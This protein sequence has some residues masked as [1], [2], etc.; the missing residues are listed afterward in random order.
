[1][2]ILIDLDNSPHVPFFLPLICEMERQ[3]HEVTITARDCFQTCGLLD[4]A[5]RDYETIGRHYGRRSVSKALGLLARSFQ[6]YRFARRR[7]FDVAASHGSRA[8]ILAAFLRRIPVV[9]IFDY[10]FSRFGPVLARLPAKQIVPSVISDSECA[11]LGCNVGRIVRYPGLK[12]QVYVGDFRPDGSLLRK[13]G[14]DPDRTLVTVRPPANEAHYHN[15][16]SEDL[17]VG[18]LRELS[19]REDVTT[20]VLPRNERQ[21]DELGRVLPADR[22]GIV[23]LDEVVDGLNLIWHSDLVV[24]GGGTMNREA[25]VLGVPVYSIFRG[26]IG[27]VDRSLVADGR[28]KLVGSLDDMRAINMTKRDKTKSRIAGG[29]ADLVG[30]LVREILTTAESFSAES[31]ARAEMHSDSSAGQWCVDVDSL[32]DKMAFFDFW[33]IPVSVGSEG[34]DV[35]ELRMLTQ[36]SFDGNCANAVVFLRPSGQAGLYQLGN[37]IRFFGR[38]RA[39]EKHPAH[40]KR[41][42]SIADAQGRIVSHVLEDVS[43]RTVYFPFSLDEVFNNYHYEAYSNGKRTVSGLALS[44]YYLVK[45]LIPRT[46]LGQARGAWAKVQARKS[47]PEFPVDR[48]FEDLKRYILAAALRVSRSERLPFVWFWPEGKEAA[49]VLTH[50]VEGGLKDNAGI[51]RLLAA[52]KKRGLASSFNIVPFKYQV[53]MSI[54][55][56]LK[57]EGCEV[58][59]HGYNH[60]GK[61]FSSRAVFEKRVDRLNAVAGLWQAAGFRAASTYRNPYWLSAMS[62]DYDSSFF[63]TDPYEPQP[64]GCLSLFPYSIGNVIEIPMTLPQDHTLLTVLKHR[65]IGMWTRKADLIREANGMIC[66]NTHPDEGYIGD[67]DRVRHYEDFLER[68]RDAHTVWNPLP[69]EL[70]AWWRARRTARV[71]E[72]GDGVRIES[73]QPDMCVRWATLDDGELRFETD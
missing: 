8:L 7:Q 16:A 35:S 25:A 61:L 38:I 47:F 29:E 56:R 65:D 14:V 55:E 18:L 19:G 42:D 12:E 54:I 48:S 64:G 31:V 17:L 3:G 69:R 63:D 71:V 72:N 33:K 62:F 73:D 2:H 6:L 23:I 41:L 59:V 68:F 57:H 22:N 43:R 39:I 1:M 37:G 49:L 30:T 40:L 50:D 21:R 51:W 46:V 10:E 27:A 24:S 44:T 26:K 66:L 58:G 4:R 36:T 9:N 11:E 32:E 52:E 45:P 15:P 60:D 20:V 5:G 13:L 28:L 67:E 34:D 53:D 70:A